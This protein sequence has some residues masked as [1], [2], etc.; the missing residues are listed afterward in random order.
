VVGAGGGSIREVI[1]DQL[2][3]SGGDELQAPALSAPILYNAESRIGEGARVQSDWLHGF[4]NDPSQEIRPWL[5]L[6]MP[7]FQFTQEQ[8]N[9]LTRGFASLDKVPYP[10]VTPP[11]QEAEMLA[12][13]RDLFGRWQ[14]QKCHVVAGKLPD[15][16]PANMAP[17]LAKVPAR[18]RPD[19]L[20]VWLADPQRVAPGTR[21]PA[22]FPAD[23][24]E[25]AFPEVLA[26]DQKKQIEAMRQYLLTLGPGP[27][28]PAAPAATAA[29]APRNAGAGTARR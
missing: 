28:S 14:C 16:E 2:V 24:Q 27:R 10:Y 9:T 19:W 26:G 12:A 3:T 7:T 15:Q 17:D 5:E 23:P 25:N 20:N 1:K 13:G 6:R 18:L 8:L 11:R 4:L 21:M 29:T 22:A